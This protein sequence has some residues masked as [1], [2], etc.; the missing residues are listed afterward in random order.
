[1]SDRVDHHEDH[2]TEG[3]GDADVAEGVGLS[4]HH[5]CARTG[6]DEC[7]RP[8]QLRSERAPKRRIH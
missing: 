1:V 8:D 5:D 3:D 2:Q 7:E 4:V 6:E